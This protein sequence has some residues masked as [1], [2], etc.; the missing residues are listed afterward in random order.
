MNWSVVIVGAT[1][2]FPGIY[3][4]FS[5][6]HKYLKESNSVLTDNVVIIGG[7]ALSAAEVLNLEVNK[8]E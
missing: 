3:W 4:I 1:L 7:K 8:K 6:R 2:V 5:A